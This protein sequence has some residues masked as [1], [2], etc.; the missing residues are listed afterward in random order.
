MLAPTIYNQPADPTEQPTYHMIDLHSFILT[1]DARTRR[2]GIK[3][4]RNS[5]DLAK[6]ARDGAI[7][8]ANKMAHDRNSGASASPSTNRPRVS[9]SAGG[10]A[11][12]VAGCWMGG[13]FTFEAQ[14]SLITQDAASNTSGITYQ[15]SER[16][17]DDPSEDTASNIS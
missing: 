13:P 11:G 16:L 5:R 6:E 4:F 9:S 8:R 14:E 3:C 17:M 1:K 12:F 15:E 10:V 7:A 2:E